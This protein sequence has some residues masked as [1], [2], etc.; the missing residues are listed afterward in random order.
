MGESVEIFTAVHHDLFRIKN[1]FLQ[2][3]RYYIIFNHI[4]ANKALYVGN[5]KNIIYSV[6]IYMYGK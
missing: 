3:P 2:H 4:Y 1:A 5:P 6:S